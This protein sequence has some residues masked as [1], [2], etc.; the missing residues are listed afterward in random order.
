[1]GVPLGEGTKVTGRREGVRLGVVVG[2]TR[3]GARRMV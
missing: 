3:G 1:M 2:K